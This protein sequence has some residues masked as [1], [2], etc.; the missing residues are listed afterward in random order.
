MQHRGDRIIMG[1]LLAGLFIVTGACGDKTATSQAAQPKRGPV[2]VATAVAVARDM[3]VELTAVGTVE[4]VATVNVKSRVSA[5]LIGVHFK[6]GQEVKQG[7]LLFTLDKAP[8]EAAIR[9]AEAQLAKDKA[10]LLKANQDL[11]RQKPLAEKDVMSRQQYDQTL[12]AAAAAQATVQADLATIEGLKLQAGFCTIRSPINGVTGSLL[13]HRGNQIKAN[14]DNKY[15]VSIRQVEP[16]YVSFA[17]PEQHLG[18]VRQAQ[19]GGRVTVAAMPAETGVGEPVTGELAFVENTVDSATGTITLK[20]SFANADRRLWP[21]R[22]VTIT[23]ALGTQTDAVVIPVQALQSGQSGRFVF[24]VG[25]DGTAQIKPVEVARTIGQQAVIAKGIA[26]G[27]QVVTEGQL[28][29]T[30]G[31][32]LAP[33]AN[34]ADKGPKS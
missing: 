21:G 9:Q 3:P 23:V 8:I 19:A 2:P 20:A 18:Q 22:I 5:E 1:L 12:A 25:P 6:E 15:L 7:D 17:L 10:L 26:P 33:K 32:A 13:I 28:M 4:A 24:V 31:A 30:P 16:V 27:D 14:D 34:N 29:L 11:A